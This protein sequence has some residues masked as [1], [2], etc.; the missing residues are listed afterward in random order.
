MRFSRRSA[1]PAAASAAAAAPA[2]VAKKEEPE[3]EEED[4]DF[5]LCAAPGAPGGGCAR[6]CRAFQMV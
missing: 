4:M 1:A 2:A 5:D 3:E 6:V